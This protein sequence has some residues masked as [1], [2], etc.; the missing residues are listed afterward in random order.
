MTA[1]PSEARV[2]PCSKCEKLFAVNMGEGCWF[3]CEECLKALRP[4]VECVCSSCDTHFMK[5]GPGPNLC[6]ACQEKSDSMAKGLERQERKERWRSLSIEDKLEDLW[7]KLDEILDR[8][9]KAWSNT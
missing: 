6:H 5:F 3:T 7:S 1:R 9:P 8:L 2:H 4:R